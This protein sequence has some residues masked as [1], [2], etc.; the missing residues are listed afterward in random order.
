ML[1]KGRPTSPLCSTVASPTRGEKKAELGALLAGLWPKGRRGQAARQRCAHPLGNAHA[2]E[3][4]DD[5]AEALLALH[6]LLAR[7]LR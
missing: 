6:R 5:G 1:G 2:D 4:A 7:L 3:G